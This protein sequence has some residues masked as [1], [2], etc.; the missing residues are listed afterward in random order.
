MY[1]Y[2]VVLGYSVILLNSLCFSVVKHTRYTFYK[3]P[4]PQ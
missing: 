2:T 3:K 1:E 4:E